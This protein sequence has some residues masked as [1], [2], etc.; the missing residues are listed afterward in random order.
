M[1]SVLRLCWLNASGI[2]IEFYVLSNINESNLNYA[3]AFIIDEKSIFKTKV[4]A[5]TS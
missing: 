4:G 5:H 1:L 3:L 2:V